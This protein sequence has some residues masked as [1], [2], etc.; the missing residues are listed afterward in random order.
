MGRRSRET[1]L[2]RRRMDGQQAHDKMLNISNYYRNAHQNYNEV[3]PH[4]NQ[5]AIINKSSNN[6]SCRGCGEKRTLLHGWW[7]WKLVEPLW[8]TVWMD[9]PQKTKHR[10]TIPSSNPTPGHVSGR[11]FHSKRYMQTYVHCTPILK[12]QDMETT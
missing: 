7:E 10:R 8:K 11:I 4:T 12:S 2:Q 1:F 6:K 9:V 5:V 3:P